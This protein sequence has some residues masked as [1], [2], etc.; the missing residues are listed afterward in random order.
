MSFLLLI[1]VVCPGA[2][3]AHLRRLE[4]VLVVK[5]NKRR[6]ASRWYHSPRRGKRRDLRLDL[7]LARPLEPVERGTRHATG[8][9]PEMVLGRAGRAVRPTSLFEEAERRRL[10]GRRSASMCLAHTDPLD[11]G[12]V[13]VR[14]TLQPRYL[15]AAERFD[16]WH[17]LTVRDPELVLVARHE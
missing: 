7:V 11:E 13:H 9:V 14:K 15:I 17:Q 8:A 2:G 1:G 16:A 6:T 4:H 5:T 10:I 3:L 12:G